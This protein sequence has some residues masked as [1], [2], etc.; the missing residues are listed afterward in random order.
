[1]DI[2]PGAATADTDGSNNSTTY[3]SAHG[4][5]RA[6][7]A[8]DDIHDDEDCMTAA[9]AA[10]QS[11]AAVDGR[12]DKRPWSSLSPSRR[13]KRKREPEEKVLEE[14]RCDGSDPTKTTNVTDEGEHHYH[15]ATASITTKKRE[16]Q[17]P[18]VEHWCY[19]RGCWV[20]LVSVLA[21]FVVIACVVAVDDDADL[22]P[23]PGNATNATGLVEDLP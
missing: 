10:G 21:T 11:Q 2:I 20:L 14:G 4:G 7:L 6:G 1:M 15:L 22:V 3:Y 17:V 19:Y 16:V 9:V 5:H 18:P 8:I 23:Y 12:R 13:S